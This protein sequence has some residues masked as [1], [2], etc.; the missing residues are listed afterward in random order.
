MKKIKHSIIAILLMASATFFTSCY[1][2]L[3]HSHQQAGS[4]QTDEAAV[5]EDEICTL[6]GGE[7]PTLMHYSGMLLD[8]AFGTRSRWYDYYESPVPWWIPVNTAREENDEVE[9][10]ESTYSGRNYGRRRAAL[11]EKSSGTTGGG[12]VQSG[13]GG[14]SGAPTGGGYTGGGAVATNP[15]V[16]TD[17][18]NRQ[19]DLDS[20]SVSTHQSNSGTNTQR[21]Y[22]GRSVRKKK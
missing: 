7:H 10:D 9:D 12:A 11:E 5:A 19:T 1:T 18:T 8:P 2:V 4:E 21:E 20:G 17:T 14:Y 15:P 13:S 6:C 3:V 16:Q 22:G